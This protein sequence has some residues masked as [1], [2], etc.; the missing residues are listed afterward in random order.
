MNFIKLVCLGLFFIQASCMTGQSFAIY[1][2]AP[3]KNLPVNKKAY[4]ELVKGLRDDLK[5]N[6]WAMELKNDQLLLD[7]TYR[8]GD[9]EVAADYLLSVY[10]TIYE[11]YNLDL[12]FYRDTAKRVIGAYFSIGPI[13]RYRVIMTDLRN[14][15]MLQF[16]GKFGQSYNERENGKQIALTAEEFKKYFGSIGP[17]ALQ[18]KSE[19]EYGKV[20]KR[21]VAEFKPKFQEYYD[22][23]RIGL[24]SIVS[25]LI[26]KTLITKPEAIQNP[27]VDNGKLKS[28]QI[29]LNKS[30][31]FYKGM[32][33]TVFSL[34]TL[35]D[36][37]IPDNYKTWV[38]EEVGP[39]LCMAESKF[40]IPSK[41][42]EAG[43][44]VESGKKLYFM[45]GTTPY[46]VNLAKEEP[47]TIDLQGKELHGAVDVYNFLSQSSRMRIINSIEEDLI[48]KIHER[49][50]GIQFVES[51]YSLSS[52]GA[53]VIL[54]S[55]DVDFIIQDAKS[56]TVIG[57]CPKKYGDKGV[58]DLL[59]KS[60]DLRIR[61]IK[62]LDFKKDALKRALVY[63]PLGFYEDFFFDI[64]LVTP[65]NVNGKT[66]YRESE[67][68]RGTIVD[69]EKYGYIFGE[70]KF[71]KGE[72]EIGAAY[73]NHQ[74]LLFVSHEFKFPFVGTFK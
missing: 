37:I 11:E 33:V 5:I 60:L 42:K 22:A 25:H 55:S 43:E 50:K 61:I 59:Q 68:G 4:D 10:Y 15:E 67:I 24:V 31:Q 53:S 69:E 70:A 14:N 54:S 47:I 74:S 21:I 7:S 45:P 12:K 39:Q 29:P 51:G 26:R 41:N 20:L 16:K 36:Y 18:A 1:I 58:Y 63:S 38:V 52:L 13:T 64:M 32:Y 17:V 3:S 23:N 49:Y 35:G 2:D 71:N 57:S 30:F 46:A 62:A 48:K 19:V 56:G 66:L 40:M 65:E 27:M 44:A 8:N 28:F 73:N 9:H 6:G 72:K 34:D